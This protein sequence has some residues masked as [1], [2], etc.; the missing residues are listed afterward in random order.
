MS[1]SI[2]RTH[3]A[4]LIAAS[5][6]ARAKDVEPARDPAYQAALYRVRIH[7]EVCPQCIRDLANAFPEIR[8]RE[9]IMA[10]LVS[11]EEDDDGE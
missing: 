10:D 2:Y 8:G 5:A 3:Y 9:L 4:A 11:T 6:A 7:A 1:C